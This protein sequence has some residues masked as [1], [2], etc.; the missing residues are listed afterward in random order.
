MIQPLTNRKHLHFTERFFIE[1]KVTLGNSN[2]ELVRLL[3]RTQLKV[4]NEI[5]SII[6]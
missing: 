3:Y 1:K 2:R 4:K 5:R 6:K